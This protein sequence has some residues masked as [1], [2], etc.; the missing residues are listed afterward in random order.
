VA[1]RPRRLTSSARERCWHR[2]RWQRGWWPSGSSAKHRAIRTARKATRSSCPASAIPLHPEAVL[3]FRFIP[4]C[5]PMPAK[6]VPAAEEWLHEVKFDG[7]RVQAHEVGSRVIGGG[8]KEAPH[9][10]GRPLGC[11]PP[12]C[13][14]PAGLRT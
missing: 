10:V 1:Q 3:E 7:Y 14:I 8:R 12:G 5:S 11:G 9:G 4:P 2:S 6:A 13:G